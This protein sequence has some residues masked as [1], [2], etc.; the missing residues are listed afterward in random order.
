MSGPYASGTSRQRPPVLR[1]C[2]MPEITCRSSTRGLP[3]LPLGK[4][5]LIVAQAASDSH[6]N[7]ATH[8]ILPPEL[9]PKAE[10]QTKAVGCLDFLHSETSILQFMVHTGAT[11]ILGFLAALEAAKLHARGSEQNISIFNGWRYL[12]S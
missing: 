9:T 10:E 1:M 8:K 2:K 5:G 12:A 4:F 6:N 3:P 7:R 11:S